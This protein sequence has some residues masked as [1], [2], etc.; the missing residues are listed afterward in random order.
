MIRVRTLSRFAAISGFV[1]A[2]VSLRP[3]FATA[4]VT[5]SA[6]LPE[7]K[8]ADVDATF[9][10]IESQDSESLA[11]VYRNISRQA[12][13]PG[14]PIGPG[15]G[16]FREGHSVSTKDC[17][18]C[19]QGEPY[20]GQ[21]VQSLDRGAVAHVLYRWK[22]RNEE[23][24]SCA[25]TGL[26]NTY[27]GRDT[28]HQFLVVAPSLI[29]HVC[30]DV[31]V[32][33][34]LAGDVSNAGSGIGERLNLGIERNEHYRGEPFV[35]HVRA[36]DAN[37]ALS[38]DEDSCPKLFLR[39]R[40]SSGDTRF[41]EI[42]SR[43]TCKA[44]STGSAGRTL[45]IDMEGERTSAAG[46]LGL[47][48]YTVQVALAG[49]TTASGEVRMVASNVISL[50]FFDP[51]EVSWNWG[52]RTNGAAV[53]LN[54]DRD[55]FLRGEAIPLH[56]A[57]EDFE[58]PQTIYTSEC[59][60]V[61]VEA[62]DADMNRL[63][64]GQG[65]TICTG[66]GWPPQAFPKQ[67][68][69]TKELRLTM[70][71]LL[72]GDRDIGLLPNFEGIYYLAVKWIFSSPGWP[73][74][75]C[76][77]DCR[78]TIWSAPMRI[79][80]A[81][82]YKRIVS[83]PWPTSPS[84]TSSDPPPG[85]AQVDTSIGPATA[86]EDMLTGLK[87]LHL[88][89]TAKQSYSTVMANMAPGKWLEG[90]RYATPEELRDLFIH[91]KRAAG[92]SEDLAL[93]AK[94]QNDLGGPLEY[95]VNHETSWARTSSTAF[96]PLTCDLGGGRTAHASYGIISSDSFFGITIKPEVSGCAIDGYQGASYL[97]K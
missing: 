95:S 4:Q 86:L 20:S 14:G 56:I 59:D 9:A 53:A 54:L 73:G 78:A 65:P 25:E 7:C 41:E 75:T 84:G 43:R 37:R 55:T 34:F 39:T 40:A 67:R 18:D 77:P 46:W 12:C 15:F 97:V 19:A 82:E 1:L 31:S 2:F 61:Y 35:L 87:W 22:S 64:S 80:I 60:E 27:V 89:L 16:N 76:A 69:V 21:M 66:H 30:S 81:D 42:R 94:M 58:A 72:S 44:N 28:Q 90:W 83:A 47:G 91:Y 10:F 36:E 74:Q 51:A 26:L 62:R 88:D 50:R 52:A 70:F 8:A 38:L 63:T 68:V 32:S 57:R 5:P 23:S 24:S 49:E 96:L 85:F 71:D 48:D 17:F 93:A 6:V 29:T 45:E 13:N 11:V 3:I 33:S 92:G 79:Q